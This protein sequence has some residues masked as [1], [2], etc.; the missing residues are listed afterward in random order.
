MTI[1][2]CFEKSP[3]ENMISTLTAKPE[4][5]IFVGIENQMIDTV[6]RYKEFLR[7]KNLNTKISLRNIDKNNLKNIVNVLTEIIKTEKDC[8][9]D[10]TGGEDLVLL[11]IGMVFATYREKY[12]FKL[13]RFNISTGKIV[14]CD[15]DNEVTFT[16][17]FKLT[18]DELILLYGGLIVSKNDSQQSKQNINNINTLWNISQKLQKQWNYTVTVLNDFEKYSSVDKSKM[19]IYIDLDESKGKIHDFDNKYVLYCKLINL[20]ASKGLIDDYSKNEKS[21][22]YRYTDNL[23]RYCLNK[24]GNLLEMKVYAEAKNLTEN[25]EPYFN[26]CYSNVIIDWDG[27]IPAPL[28]S[29]NTRNEIDIILMRGLTPIFISC[30]NGSIEETEPYKLNT[31]ATR[32]GGNYAK[33]VIIASNFERETANAEQAFFTRMK[34]MGIFFVHNANSF[35]DDDWKKTLKR[36]YTF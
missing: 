18:V 31:V 19:R 25:G 6:Q 32:F 9:F 4:K 2:E 3:I 11:A 22:T 16:D 15:C 21:I 29:K 27:V 10:I 34:D 1:I 28:T 23:I 8:I 30:K 12:P 24:A 20:M 13:Q 14:D 26:S 17:E 5:L 36:L 35:S 7:S 33:K